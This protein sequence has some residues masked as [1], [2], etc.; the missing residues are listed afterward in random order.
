MSDEAKVQFEQT[1]QGA[2]KAS[3]DGRRCQPEVRSRLLQRLAQAS[4]RAP[5]GIDEG[6]LAR[7]EAA[8]AQAIQESQRGLVDGA[9]S[10]RVEAALGQATSRD[11]RSEQTVTAGLETSRTDETLANDPKARYLLALQGAVSRSHQSRI[12][13]LPLRQNILKALGSASALT[14]SGAEVAPGKAAP[15]TAKVVHLQARPRWRRALTAAATIAAGFALFFG[16]LMGGAEEALAE[17][18]RQDHKRC[19]ESLKASEMASCPPFNSAEFGPLPPTQVTSDWT[20]VAS[21][22]CRTAAGGPMVHNVYL[23]DG[24]TISLHFLPSSAAAKPDS[25]PRQIAQGEFPV[26]AWESSGW[27]VTA[28]SSDLDMG[29]LASAVGCAPPQ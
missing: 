29:T 2:I 17:S 13:P 14:G 15:Q 9:V 27:T 20:L 1:L 5:A 28:C 8:M 11:L 16:T 19:C 21:R 24:A 7:F 3:L 25:V 23:R 18:V 26:I 6:E 12:T 4:E 22:M 10:Q